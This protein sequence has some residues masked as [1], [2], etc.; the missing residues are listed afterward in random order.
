MKHF[1]WSSLGNWILDKPS[2]N[3]NKGVEFVVLLSSGTC[4]LIN[5]NCLTRSRYDRLSCETIWKLLQSIWWLFS[6]SC[7]LT[8]DFWLLL[9]GGEVTGFEVVIAVVLHDSFFNLDGLVRSVSSWLH[10]C[11]LNG[12]MDPSTPC[13]INRVIHCRSV[14][15]I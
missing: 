12:Y 10:W 15:P 14:F 1:H 3:T 7:C 5:K 6:A 4:A 11:F 2:G 13:S 9:S 8:A